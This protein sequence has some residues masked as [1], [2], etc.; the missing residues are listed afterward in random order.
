MSKPYIKKTYSNGLTLLTVPVDTAASVTMSIFVKAGSR[1]E[2]SRVNG[3]SHYLE[4]V[5]FKGTKKYPTTKILSEVVDSI[6]G[7]FNANTGKEHT[8]YYISAAKEHLDVIFD[9]LTELIKNPIFDEKELEREKGVI[10]EEINMY[11]DN[12]QIH[13]EA[14]F[15]ETLWPGTPLGRDIAGT[16]EKVKAISRDDV[17]NYR[18]KWY[19]PSNMIIAVA[20]NFSQ[21]KIEKLV[22]RKWGKVKNKKVGKWKLAKPTKKGPKLKIQNKAT[23][24]AHMFVGFP[25]Y[26]YDQKKNYPLKVLSAILGAGLSSRLFIQI[27]E[28]KGLAYYVTS[29]T[30]NYL[31][32]GTFYV[33]SGLKISS[34]P[35][36]LEMILKELRKI[37]DKGITRAEL[38]KAKEQIK[39]RLALGLENTHEKL[40]WNLG[41]EAFTDK[42]VSIEK[43]FENFNKVKL[44]EVNKVARELIRQDRLHVAIIGPFP[45]KKIF[46]DRMKL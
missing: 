32:T 19:K 22:D 9:V 45:D 39:G 6:G 38:K 35:E 25:A 41:Q 18:N 13:V 28:R 43:T 40:D 14:L 36:A 42:I 34:A 20:G 3:I 1:Y 5:H 30:E 16:A 37:R 10:L 27:R 7:E 23:E 21:A 24:Q 4:H 46:E 44:E 15:E 12:P 31:D 17:I 26:S 29:S 2:E 11:K 8:Q 33:K